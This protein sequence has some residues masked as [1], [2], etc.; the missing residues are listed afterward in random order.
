MKLQLGDKI[1]RHVQNF[2]NYFKQ[3]NLSWLAAGNELIELKRLRVWAVDGSE[4]RSWREWVDKSLLISGNTADRLIRTAERFGDIL[5][6]N[7]TYAD[8]DPSKL[9]LIPS[10]VGQTEELL[11]WIERA[12]NL[13]VR[14]LKDEIAD[15]RG[16][17]TTDDHEHEWV[18][19]QRCKICGIRRIE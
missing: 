9:E 10:S 14:Q 16:L 6:K 12:R 2:H 7:P 11:G 3:G 8:T 19:I 17:V 5:L 4:S 1:H 13:S 18:L 15:S